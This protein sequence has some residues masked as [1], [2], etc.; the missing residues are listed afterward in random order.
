M[1]KLPAPDEL[2]ENAFQR[3]WIEAEGFNDFRG[4]HK[5]AVALCIIFINTTGDRSCNLIKCRRSDHTVRAEQVTVTYCSA[6]GMEVVVSGGTRSVVRHVNFEDQVFH[7]SGV[8]FRA[9]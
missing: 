4:I 7:T 9:V 2:T 6:S 3:L 1:V 8:H 5:R